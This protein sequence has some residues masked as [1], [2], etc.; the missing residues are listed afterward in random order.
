A[1]R[2][3]ERFTD[4]AQELDTFPA[5]LSASDPSA[6][7]TLY[8]LGAER[9]LR[10]RMPDGLVID[11]LA[12]GIEDAGMFSYVQCYAAPDEPFFCVEPWMGFPNAL[13]AGR[14]VR[15][16]GPGVSEGGRLRISIA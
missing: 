15:W 10:L 8:Q 13:N 4:L 2:Y 6:N 11:L 9:Q 16:L 1:F 14:G 7:N 5:S 3:N 12:E